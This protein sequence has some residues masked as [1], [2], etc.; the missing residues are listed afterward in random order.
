[1][2]IAGNWKMFKGPTEA[3]AFCRTL[4]DVDLPEDVDV[5]VCPPYV[6]LEGRDAAA[7]RRPGHAAQPLEL[8]RGHDL[9]VDVAHDQSIA[10]GSRRTLPAVDVAQP[11]RLHQ[12]P[13]LEVRA[14][15]VEHLALAHEVVEGAQ[16]LLERRRVVDVVDE[17]DVDIVGLQPLQHGLDLLLDVQ[18]RHAEIVG[19]RAHRVEQLAGDH[20]LVPLALQRLSQHGLRRAADIGV[21]RVEEVDAGGQRRIDHPACAGLVGAVAEGHG[22]EADLRDLEARAA[23][24][25][26]R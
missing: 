20:R 24:I 1:M 23:E 26:A 16:H 2:L 6:S 4:R 21:R 10:A 17:E 3:A 19:P 13:C 9:L 25:G 7:E 15:G 11:Q 8:Q 22:A 12:P 5:V 18:P 14:R